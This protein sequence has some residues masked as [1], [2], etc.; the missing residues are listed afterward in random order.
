MISS[1][2]NDPAEA[3]TTSSEIANELTEKVWYYL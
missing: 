1:H 3:E 2:R